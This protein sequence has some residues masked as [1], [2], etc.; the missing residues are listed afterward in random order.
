MDKESFKS[1]GCEM[2]SSKELISKLGRD[3][4]ELVYEYDKQMSLMA[5]AECFIM[6]ARD[7]VCSKKLSYTVTI[8]LLTE[9]MTQDLKEQLVS[10][11][12]EEEKEEE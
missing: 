11:H 5:I 2:E 1:C 3:I 4:Y 10:Y 9:M 12:F 7:L 6:A 8:G